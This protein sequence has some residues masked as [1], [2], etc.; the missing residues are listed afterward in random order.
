MKKH[1]RPEDERDKSAERMCNNIGKQDKARSGRT[2]IP[3]VTDVPWSP[4][5]RDSASRGSVR[6]SLVPQERSQGA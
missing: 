2:R 4:D 1:A 6:K 3:W 5:W